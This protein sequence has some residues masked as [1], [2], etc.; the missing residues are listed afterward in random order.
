MVISIV[1]NIIQLSLR[2]H[3]IKLERDGED[4]IIK[5]SI[6]RNR[7]NLEKILKEP[8][9]KLP[10]GF[11]KWFP[12]MAV[13]VVLVL[14]SIKEKNRQKSPKCYKG[15]HTKISPKVDSNKFKSYILQLLTRSKKGIRVP[16]FVLCMWLTILLEQ[17][18]HHFPSHRIHTSIYNKTHW[19]KSCN[20]SHYDNSAGF[21]LVSGLYDECFLITHGYVKI[22]YRI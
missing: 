2:R 3:Q 16:Y 11:F 5:L 18:Q 9:H 1:Y 15:F 20:I 13:E 21:M 14:S 12:R 4:N 22:K 10:Q 7:Q 8:I 19:H 17:V 6:K